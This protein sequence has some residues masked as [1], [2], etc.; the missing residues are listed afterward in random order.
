[1]S[2]ESPRKMQRSG[3]NRA[4]ETLGRDSDQWSPGSNGGQRMGTPGKGLLRPKFK[5]ADASRRVQWHE[6]LTEYPE[7]IGRPL[8]ARSSASAGAREGQSMEQV[9]F[10]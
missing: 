5:K 8:T 1:M 7:K 4:I 2:A 3:G 10:V 9:C 6:D